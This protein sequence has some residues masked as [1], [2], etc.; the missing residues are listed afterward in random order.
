MPSAAE[1]FNEMSNRFDADKAGDMNASVQFSL[2]GDGGGDWYV[3]IANGE[4]DAQEGSLDSPTAKIL[5]SANDYVAMTTGELNAM[6]A[7]MGGKIKV[8]GDLNTVMKFQG[9]FM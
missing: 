9:L 8:E 5:M 6:A 1:I 7:F 4:C 2:S 3:K